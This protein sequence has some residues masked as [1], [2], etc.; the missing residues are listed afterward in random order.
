MSMTVL[1]QELRELIESGPM[2]HLTT[3][4]DDGS[5]QVTVIWIGLDGENIVS[6][7]MSRRLKVRNVERDPRVVL[8]FDAPA[9]PGTFLRPYAVLKAT[10]TIEHGE[11]AW[12]LLNRLAKVYVAPGAEFPAAKASGWVMR[13]SVARIS[14]VGPWAP[15]SH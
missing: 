3:I 5:P 4:N 6:G 10:A 1:P 13:Y 11:K 2:A 7:H 14:G 8:S 9:E 15:S 12:D